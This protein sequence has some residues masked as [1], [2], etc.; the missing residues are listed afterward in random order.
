ALPAL[1]LFRFPFKLLP[2]TTL[3][4][5]A[6]AG[7]GWD[8][9]AAGSG[10]RRTLTIGGALLVLTLLG[11]SA[12]VALRGRLT[13]AIASRGLDHAVFGP[14]DASGAVADVGRGLAH[15]AIALA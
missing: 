5:S 11:L 7:L 6:L 9:F 3:G 8:R 1:R 10:R 13:A 15:G 4:I 2:L 14:L 12:T